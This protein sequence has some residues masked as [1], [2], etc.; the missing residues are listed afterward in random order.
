LFIFRL[1]VQPVV[2]HRSAPCRD[3]G[4]GATVV[5][6]PRSGSVAGREGSDTCG[7]AHRPA[8][9]HRSDRRPRDYPTRR[10]LDSPP[11]AGALASLRPR[12]A[13]N[14]VCES[15]RPARQPRPLRLSLVLRAERGISQC[16]TT[17]LVCCVVHLKARATAPGAPIGVPLVNHCITLR[18]YLVATHFASGGAGRG[19]MF[20][21]A[22]PMPNMLV[23]NSGVVV[24]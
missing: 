24:T 5:R 14:G 4:S 6:L 11:C 3:D 8:P 9:P 18:C 19:I 10:S 23:S 12:H 1:V 22:Y 7:G 20:R 21:S 13:D 15:N 2:V 16:T 17:T